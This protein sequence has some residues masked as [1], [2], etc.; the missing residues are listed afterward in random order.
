[1]NPILLSLANVPAAQ[2]AASGYGTGQ[3]MANYGAQQQAQAQK[4][5][6]ANE[7]ANRDSIAFENEKIRKQREQA[8]IGALTSIA[9]AAIGGPL[10]AGGL[11]GA[12]MGANVGS[13][14]FGQ[15]S[16]IGSALS[17][18]AGL[19]EKNQFRTDLNK[20]FGGK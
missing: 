12:A 20:N 11:G 18:G 14:L 5:A 8:Q 2:L 6:M 1:M 16:P 15:P 13:A 3:A 10:L 17:M 4:N 19:Q 9:G 7:Q